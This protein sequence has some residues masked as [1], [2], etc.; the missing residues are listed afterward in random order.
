MKL[1][2]IKYFT[3]VAFILSIMSCE[4]LVEV[5]PPINELSSSS[6][7][8]NDATATS[9]LSGV[10]STLS[11]ADFTSGGPIDFN[12]LSGKMGD[13]FT[14]HNDELYNA[15]FAENA[16]TP[17][18]SYVM[19][20]WSSPYTIIYQANA[21][22]SGLKDN[23]QVSA[24]LKVQL[25]GESYFLRA[26]S[27]LFLVSAFGDVP[28]VTTTNYIENNVAKRSG[29][30]AVYDA[31]IA[32]LKIA[33]ELLADNYPSTGRVRGNKWAASALLARAYLYN[34]MWTDAASEATQVINQSSLYSLEQ[35]NL[36]DTFLSTNQESIW[37]IQSSAPVTNEAQS[38]ILYP[39]FGPIDLQVSLTDDL[40]NSFELGD[41]RKT[42]W[43]GQTND[44][45][46]DW[47]YPYKYKSNWG[48]TRPEN[49]VRLRLAELYL[50]RAEARANNN[51]L[52]TAKDDIDVIR[53][54][55]GLLP[56]AATTKAALLLAVEKERRVEL[57]SEDGHRWKD[58]VRT[59]RAL[60]VLQAFKGQ[61][62]Q[63]HETLLP[64]PFL[65]IEKNK[66]LTQNSGY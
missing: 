48:N 64:I 19:T 27:H 62:F 29:Q 45:T 57:F 65:E 10:Y 39:G 25:V 34:K 28:L 15:Q 56:T 13:E 16:I 22:I 32:D 38:F 51:E 2:I 46:M 8:T 30:A 24:N 40:F 54:R 42:A 33:K 53:L 4:K 49:S 26:Y 52:S 31:I 47:Y 37:Q 20:L 12:M 11:T 66:N 6:V 43:V 35:T 60:T 17:Q 41:K 23:T 3:L 50:I 21:L 14:N 1:N 7:F 59:G 9:A 44:G 63:A 61:S 55:A 36:S 58:L 18:N 5:S